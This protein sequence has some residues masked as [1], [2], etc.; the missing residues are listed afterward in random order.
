MRVNVP[1]GGNPSLKV[2]DATGG[3]KGFSI[4]NVSSVDV[5]YSDDQRTLDTVPASFLP[6]AGHLLPAATPTL[7]PVVYPFFVNGK[8]FVRAQS[9]GAQIEVVIFDVDIPC[10]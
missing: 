10:K 3:R 9:A 7:A 4:Q 5:Y 8:I 6:Q 2:V 1:F